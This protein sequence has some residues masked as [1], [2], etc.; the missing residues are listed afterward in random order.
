MARRLDL[1]PGAPVLRIDFTPVDV[2]GQPMVYSEMF[3]RGDRFSYKA[4]VRR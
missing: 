4:V 2:S 1:A 3:F